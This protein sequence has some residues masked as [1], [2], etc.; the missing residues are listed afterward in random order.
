MD[1]ECTICCNSSANPVIKIGEDWLCTICAS[2]KK[3]FDPKILYEEQKF[4]DELL[5]KNWWTCMVGISGGKDSTAT[6]L[7]LLDRGVTPLAFTFDIWYDPSSTYYR[8]S[9]LAEKLQVPYE[10]ID[11]RSHITDADRTCYRQLIEAYQLPLDTTTAKKFKERYAQGRDHYNTKDTTI[12]PYIRP[13]QICRKIVIKAYYA[14][15]KKRGVDIIFLG[16]N[17]RTHLSATGKYSA[18]RAL[19]PFANE[20][21]VYIVHLPYLLQ[22]TLEETKKIIQQ[23]DWMPPAGDLLVETNHNSCLLAAA[24]ERKFIDLLGFHPDC[25]R[26]SREVT[27]WFLKKSEAMAALGNI[28][29]NAVS[30]VEILQQAWII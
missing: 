13:C 12:L 2:Y 20:P 28:P 7:T 9:E 15:A 10:R 30:L 6:L 1:T 29:T 18:I 21:P 16:M 25:M 14:E 22:R 24:T 17:E 11:I 5:T 4:I 19:Q 8:A 26:L 3:Q 23:V 27:V